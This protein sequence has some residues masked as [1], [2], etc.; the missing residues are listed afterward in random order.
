M[1]A[2]KAMGIVFSNIYDSSLGELTNHRTVASLPFGGRYRQID[3][4]LSNM[5]NSG[6]YN[7]GLIT[8]YNYRSLMDHLGSCT[9]W[10]L[11]R[12]NEGLV[13]LPP[14]V[15]GNTGVYKGKLEALYSA[16]A[17]I[18]NPNYDYVIVSDSTVLCNIDLRDAI[19]QH[20][21]SGVDV[22]IIS[23]KEKA[24]G[25]KHHLSIKANSKDRVT[26]LVIDSAAEEDS[27]VGM[28]MF[29]FSRELLVSAI[30]E[31]YAKGYV[32][33]ERDF[34]Q[35]AFNENLLK[36]G[37]Y[38]FDG[39][40]LRNEDIKSYYLNNMALLDEKVRKGLFLRDNPIYTKV[41]DEIPTYYG[42]GSKLTDCLVADGCTMHGKVEK[43]IL[44]RGVTVG[45]GAEIKSSIIMQ[46][47][48]IGKNARLECV[49]LDKN[50]TVS[51]GA[52][53]IGTPEHPVIVK[54][55]ETV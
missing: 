20:I 49:I 2:M 14:F 46:G 15:S 30:R 25:I 52:V 53:L 31:C 26:S 37:V 17:F 36:L 42:K 6:I 11:N 22:T 29:I 35:R 33:L 44:F 34:I 48:K 40:V 41:R 18:D 10:D 4:V 39:V 8:K 32:H 7:I 13:I 55:G 16:V 1:N 5:S 24:D 47:T 3:F 23:C 21:Q 54:K 27:L 12:K 45:E 51:E 43:S 50:V 19:E 28:G 9:E 38:K